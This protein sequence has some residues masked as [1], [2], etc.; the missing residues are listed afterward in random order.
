MGS[1]IHL[2][3]AECKCKDQ[4]ESE[5]YVSGGPAKFDPIYKY[6]MNFHLTLACNHSLCT[7]LILW[8]DKYGSGAKSVTVI[9]CN[10]KEGR[11][12]GSN[13]GYT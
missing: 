5:Q 6:T 1:K 12:V 4:K 7:V 11:E 2:L 10:S 9:I 8:F 3:Q 13:D